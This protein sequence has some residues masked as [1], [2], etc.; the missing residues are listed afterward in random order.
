MQTK[1]QKNDLARLNKIEKVLT[2]LL[3]QED[4]NEEKQF[5]LDIKEIFSLE[6]IDLDHV[7]KL[8]LVNLHLLKEHIDFLLNPKNYGIYFNA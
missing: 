4:S 1:D 5:Y 2:D 7:N 3:K 8:S 6:G